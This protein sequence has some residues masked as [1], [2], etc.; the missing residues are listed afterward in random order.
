MNIFNNVVACKL[1]KI[2]KEQLKK[3]RTVTIDVFYNLLNSPTLD[4]LK[5]RRSRVA[6]AD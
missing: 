1:P 6:F 5:K 4:N 3:K 2:I